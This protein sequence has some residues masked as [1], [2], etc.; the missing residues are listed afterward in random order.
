[1][2]IGVLAF[3]FVDISEFNM[4]INMFNHIFKLKETDALMLFDHDGIDKTK[5]IKQN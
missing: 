2:L 5:V 3:I 4:L 1:M